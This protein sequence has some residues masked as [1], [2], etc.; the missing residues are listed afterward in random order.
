MKASWKVPTVQILLAYLQRYQNLYM[1]YF[2]TNNGELKTSWKVPTLQILLAYL[3]KYQN[4]Y[5]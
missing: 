4:L 2:T 3:Q 1:K 5:M